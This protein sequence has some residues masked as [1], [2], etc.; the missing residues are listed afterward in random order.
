MKSGILR[1]TAGFVAAGLLRSR[2]APC[3]SR[4]LVKA[5]SA[6]S[7]AASVIRYF[8]SSD[9]VNPAAENVRQAA[10]LSRS[11]EVSGGSQRQTGSLSSNAFSS[12]GLNHRFTPT[13]SMCGG[14]IQRLATFFSRSK[15]RPSA[16]GSATPMT[17]ARVGATSRISTFSRLSPA[18]MPGPLIKNDAS[19][20][21]CTG[22]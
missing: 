8:Q 1:V 11:S 15:S 2:G 13:V 18:G 22:R 17:P 5:A 20:P 21:R 16:D 9:P 7:G 10:S 4:Q 12:A 6:P 3:L 19:M 14:L